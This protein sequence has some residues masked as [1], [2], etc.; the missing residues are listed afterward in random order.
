[1]FYFCHFLLLALDA[2][3]YLPIVIQVVK[4][5]HHTGVAQFTEH[6][7]QFLHYL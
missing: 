3:V 7:W 6:P 1:M 2:K 5:S 4:I